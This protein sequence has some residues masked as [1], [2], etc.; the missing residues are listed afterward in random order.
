[1]CAV[2]FARSELHFAPARSCQ[3]FLISCFLLL[4]TP[5]LI[6]CSVHSPCPGFHFRYHGHLFF[7]S[8]VGLLH[9]LLKISGF[10]LCRRPTSFVKNSRAILVHPLISVR[11]HFF[12]CRWFLVLPSSPQFLSA[13]CGLSLRAQVLAL[14]ELVKSA[15]ISLVFFVSPLSS[16]LFGHLRWKLRSIR[17]PLPIEALFGSVRPLP[18]I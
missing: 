12:F 6:S 18:P 8:G 16:A 1:V 15:P 7:L 9:R 3:I 13:S 11:G 4:H 5:D 17:L 14:A 10:S 2:D